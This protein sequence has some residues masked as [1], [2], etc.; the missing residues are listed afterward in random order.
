MP[1]LQTRI[2]RGAGVELSARP[3]LRTMRAIGTTAIVAVTDPASADK[4]ASILREELVAI[5]VACSRFRDDSEVRALQRANGARVKVSALL[6]DAISVA[7]D[8]ARRTDGAVDPTVGVAIEYLGYDKDFAEVDADG[9][10][11]EMAPA[12]A[13]GWWQIEL[14]RRARTVRVPPGTHIDLGASAKALVADRA[15]RRIAESV[16][17]GALVS[18]GGD[19]ATAGG[20]PG[21]GWTVGIASDS[22]MPVG[23]V[24][25]VVSIETGGLASSSTTVRAWRRGGRRL[26]HIVDPATGDS[27]PPYWTLVSASGAS[28]VDANAVSTAALVWGGRAV[29]KLVRLAQ[30]VRLVRHDGQVLTLNGWP[31]DIGPDQNSIHD[32]EETS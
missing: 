8:V 32:A 10:G 2:D 17:T 27:A 9:A 6:F 19:V 3:V 31:S 30:P 15:A 13:P 28:C 14:D 23:A 21:G 22:S 12:P 20:A 7:C 25:Q 11:L 5:D 26:H 4:A 29:P 16:R 24:D 1:A 18:I